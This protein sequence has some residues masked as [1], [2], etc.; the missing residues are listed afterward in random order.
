VTNAGP[1]I[2]E[3]KHSPPLPAT[4]QPVVV[5][6]R[7]H[8]V[9][10]LQPTLL[11]RI[12]TVTNPTPAYIS[13]PMNDNGAA[14]DA[15]AGD[16]IFSATIPGQSAG[17]VVAFL[18][19]AR[20]SLGGTNLFPA[21]LKSN[22]GVP[23]ECVVGFGD[24]TPAGS[25]KHQHVFITQNWA[26]RWAQGAPGVSH[27]EHDG[28][29]VDGGGR[30]IYDWMGRYAG[31]PYHQYL[32]SPIYNVA[33]QHWEVPRDDLLYGVSALDKEHVPGNGALDDDTLQREQACYW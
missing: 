24:A 13:V 14:G 12:D 33:G 16:G 9:N 15:V 2:Y 10:P 11:Y 17:T 26:N 20:D 29:W 7:F 23:R 28:T 1:A 32:G 8:D 3:V 6:A 22:A 31:S 21:D 5:S 4:N 30:I 19:S 27:E 25:F 18:V